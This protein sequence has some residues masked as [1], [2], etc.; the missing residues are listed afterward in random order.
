M[1]V[2]FYSYKHNKGNSFNY[3]VKFFKFYQVQCF[4]SCFR[5]LITIW[6][7]LIESSWVPV[8]IDGGVSFEESMVGQLGRITGGSAWKNQW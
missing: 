7:L 3:I 5:L 4:L 6:N 2:I 1:G 8:G